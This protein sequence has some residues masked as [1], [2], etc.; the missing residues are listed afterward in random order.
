M[1]K[2]SARQHQHLEQQFSSS[3]QRKTLLHEQVS[4]LHGLGGTGEAT[5]VLK[6][7]RTGKGSRGEVSS[8]THI[9]AALQM[10]FHVQSKDIRE[11]TP[12]S[13]TGLFP[14]KRGTHIKEGSRRFKDTIRVFIYI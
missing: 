10:S 7:V 1:H 14:P 9:S 2:P 11:K 3:L 12:E 8:P 4:G 6:D 5:K 13:T